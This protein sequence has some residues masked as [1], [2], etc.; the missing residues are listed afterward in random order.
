MFCA[1][2]SLSIQKAI[3]AKSMFAALSILVYHT[4]KNPSSSRTMF[5]WPTPHPKL[6]SLQ[7]LSH[8]CVWS[9]AYAV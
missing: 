1:A 7:L 9:A 6:K 5:G 3:E 8:V 4:F 2:R